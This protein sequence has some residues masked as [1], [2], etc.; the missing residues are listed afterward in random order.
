MNAF[1]VGDHAEGFKDLNLD[2]DPSP[3]QRSLGLCWNVKRDTFIFQVTDTKKPFTRRG[4]LA[5]VNSLFDPLGFVAPITQSI[6]GK[7][8]LRE[9]SSEAFDWDSPLPEDKRESWEA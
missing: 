6:K 2:V 3:I 8:L 7:F 1:L 9:L 4:I 5:T